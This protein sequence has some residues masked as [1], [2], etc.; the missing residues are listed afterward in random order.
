MS[1]QDSLDL[2]LDII[3][4]TFFRRIKTLLTPDDSPKKIMQ[5]TRVNKRIKQSGDINFI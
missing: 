2:E 4:I 5:L 3:P 1:L